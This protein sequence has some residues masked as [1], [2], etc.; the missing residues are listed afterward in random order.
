[1]SP[2]PLQPLHAL[3]ANQRTMDSKPEAHKRSAS[4]VDIHP[5]DSSL[6]SDVHSASAHEIELK[7]EAP[8][9]P[10]QPIQTISMATGSRFIPAADAT[11]LTG[12]PNAGWHGPATAQ[13]AG[14]PSSLGKT[15]KSN[16]SA[17]ILPTKKNLETPYTN[18]RSQKTIITLTKNS[19][20]D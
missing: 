8:M 19:M 15:M 9:Q 14:F 7:P 13:G 20:T 10:M 6:G 4:Q 11:G 3:A 5:P 12:T 16:D 18:E 2:A 1:M 17:E